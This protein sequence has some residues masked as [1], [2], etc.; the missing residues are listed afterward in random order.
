MSEP[1][2]SVVLATHNPQRTNLAKVLQALNQQ[3]L[4]ATSWE[5]L[6]IDNASHQPVEQIVAREEHRCS[7]RIIQEP[8]LGLTAARWRGITEAR[9]ELVV[10][11]D[12]DNCLQDDYLENSVR[13]FLEQPRLGAAGG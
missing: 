1:R 5:V 11:V 9:A 2:L 8:R 10:F 3:T 12:D 13:Q 6:I 7:P 4:P